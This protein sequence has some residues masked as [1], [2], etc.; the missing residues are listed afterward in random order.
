MVIVSVSWGAKRKKENKEIILKLCM[1]YLH[2]ITPVCK[3]GENII[4]KYLLKKKKEA[5]IKRSQWHG[6]GHC[7]KKMQKWCNFKFV[8]ISIHHP[9]TTA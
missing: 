9:V 8:C 6:N 2:H 1:P 7:K 4:Y 3:G 5:P